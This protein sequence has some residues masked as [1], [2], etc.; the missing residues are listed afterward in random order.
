MRGSASFL[1]RGTLQNSTE[2]QV[3]IIDWYAVAAAGQRSNLTSVVWTVAPIIPATT[4]GLS[5]RSEVRY[6]SNPPGS[7]RKHVSGT[8]FVSVCVCVCVI[9][10]IVHHF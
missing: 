7:L 1:G 2:E 4:L 5:W 10:A 3:S 9:F 8:T 6:D